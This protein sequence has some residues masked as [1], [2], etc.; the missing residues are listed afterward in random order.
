MRDGTKLKDIA[1]VLGLSIAT[2]SRALNNK[3]DIS[4]QTRKKVL[5]TAK[6]ME[7]QL[8]KHQL[9]N[10]GSTYAKVVGVVIPLVNHY[11]FS[12]LL[13]GIMS[14][15]NL[16]GYQVVVGESLHD[17][18]TEKKILEE[19]MDF[20]VSGILFA[21]CVHS[22]FQKNLLPVI[23]SR[24]PAVVMDRIYDN[25]LGN[26]VLTDDFNGAC[27]AVK[28]LYDQGYNYIAHI[29]S[30]DNRSVGMER[31]KGYKH[32]MKKLNLNIPD[33]YIIRVDLTDTEKSINNA[34]KAT[35]NL[36][37]LPEPPDAI[38][39]VTDDAALGVYKF[40]NENDIAI[41]DDLGVVGFSNSILSRHVTPK[42][43]TIEQNGM[44]MGELAF[45]YYLKALHSN[46]KVFQK[47]FDAQLIVRESSI[48]E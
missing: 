14:K 46:G 11:F 10:S 27:L 28:H 4:P 29:G 20:S 40:A 25:Y 6:A 41:P 38:F 37:S 26:Y 17:V 18:K 24:I 13:K 15:A 39:A 36:F 19:F 33:N 2:V 44:A 8:A 5:E 23:H 7:Y 45:D 12:T 16:H 3:S 34:Y 30:L 43:S 31:R 1:K 22:D 42:L 32:A 35:R 47:T 48:R 21:P 9:P